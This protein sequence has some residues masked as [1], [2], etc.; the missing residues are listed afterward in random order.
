[1][2]TFYPLSKPTVI[3]HA[4]LSRTKLMITNQSDTTL[5]VSKH[6]SI[7]DFVARSWPV[8]LDGVFEMEG[9]ECYKGPV[10]AMCET[11]SDVRIWES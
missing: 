8:K 5:S 10:F 4:N 6:E 7:D 1:M 2:P 9:S 3:V 11:L